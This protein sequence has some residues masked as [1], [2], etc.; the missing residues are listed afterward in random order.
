VIPTLNEASNIKHVLSNL[1]DFIDEIVV[2]DGNS[3]DGTIYEIKRLRSNARII[4]EKP[5]G[6]SA[7]MKT[8]FMNAT[9]ILSL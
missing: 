7:A 2:V 3:T 6:K 5:G 8:G 1:P 9:V 4:V